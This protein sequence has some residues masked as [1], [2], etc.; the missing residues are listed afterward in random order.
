MNKLERKEMHLHVMH[1]A[2]KDRSLKMLI[3]VCHKIK[4]LLATC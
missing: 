4:L 3:L 1:L 2:V